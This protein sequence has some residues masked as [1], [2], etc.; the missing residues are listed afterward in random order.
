MNKKIILLTTGFPYGKGENFIEDEM[1]NIPEDISLEIVP[2]FI[3]EKNTIKRGVPGNITL[4]T[5]C[6][7]GKRRKEIGIL[8]K[9]IVNEDF[10]KEIVERSIKSGFSIKDILLVAGFYARALE[11]KKRLEKYYMKELRDN[12]IVFYSYW[13]LEGAYAISLLKKKYGCNAFARAHRVDVWDGQS[14]YNVVPAQK[15]V[16]KYLDKVFVCS[17]AGKEYL[18]NKF[19]DSREVFTCSY[20]GTED[21]GYDLSEKGIPFVIVS[22][23]RIEPV[24]RVHFLAEALSH[25]TDKKIKWIH[26]GDGSERNKVEE[27][28]KN[29]PENI[30]VVLMGTTPHE[31]VMRYYKNNHVDLFINTSSSEGLPVSIMEAIS[32]GIPVIAT[33]VGGTREIV[34]PETG[35]LLK[36]DYET[37]QLVSC[38]RKYINMDKKDYVKARKS[39]RNFW[40][41]NFAANSNYSRFYSVIV[42]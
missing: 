15:Y 38:I 26:F 40:E 14:V 33:D 36:C 5:E 1:K 42:K 22:C 10:W 16:V 19:K 21:C 34:V 23:A 11:L 28:I 41:K 9:I 29:I 39:A 2:Y 18:K 30:D 25:I 12:S 35:M 17:E 4:N 6:S 3:T 8:F 37:D 24:K 32:F 13:L 20:L 31:K 27:A 7:I